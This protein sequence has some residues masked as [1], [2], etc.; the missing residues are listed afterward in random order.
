MGSNCSFRRDKLNKGYY[1]EYTTKLTKIKYMMNYVEDIAK[2]I[3]LF[4]ATCKSIQYLYIKYI[5]IDNMSWIDL[6]Y[7][8]KVYCGYIGLICFVQR[9]KILKSLQFFI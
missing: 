1:N 6:L 9:L 5:D 3:T 4:L 7:I 8:L 2:I